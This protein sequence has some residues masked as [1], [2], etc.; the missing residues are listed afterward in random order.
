M[1]HKKNTVL[2]PHGIFWLNENHQLGWWFQKAYSYK[3]V[4]TTP[5]DLLLMPFGLATARTNK[6]KGVHN[7]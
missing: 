6:S 3:Y 2:H 4:I 5:F 7:G 1:G